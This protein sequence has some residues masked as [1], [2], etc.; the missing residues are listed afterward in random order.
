MGKN[1]KIRQKRIR[2]P[3][4]VGPAKRFAS[5]SAWPLAAV[6]ITAVC[7]SPALTNGF[8]NWDDESYVV[9]NALLRGPQWIGIF[10]RPVVS[11]Y[12]PLTV[13]SL[14]ANYAI[15][16]TEPWSYLLFNLLLHL[17]NTVLVFWFAYLLSDK[18]R[19]V[20][21]FT[22]LLFGIHPMHVE[23]VAWISERKDVLYALFFL[24][25]LIAYWKYL[26]TNRST[27][28]WAC[29]LLFACSLLSK[30]AAIVLPLVLLLLDYWKKRPF[31]RRVVLE[32]IPFFLV[33]VL[34]AV[35]TLKLQSVTAMI[36]LNLYPFWVRLFFA[37]YAIIVYLAR[38]F[39]PHPLSAFHPFPLPD[40]LGW[41]IYLSPIFLLALIFLIWHFRKNRLVVFGLLFF[42]INILLVLQLV[43][44]GLTIVSERYTYVPYIG[45]AFLVTMIVTR[46]VSAKRFI[47]A[48]AG[49][50][51]VFS[52]FGF[53]SFKRTQ[54]WKDSDSLWT[55]VINRYPNASLP[56][57]DRAQFNY[58]RAIMMEPTQ[59]KP[60]FQRVIDDCTVV[61]NNKEGG[62][63]HYF[64]RGV[65]SSSLKQYEN[66]LADFNACLSIN[67]ADNEALYGRGTL[68]VNH[69]QKYA[70]ALADFDRAIQID[71]QG[72]Y[73]LNRSICHYK[74]GE[75]ANAVADA[76]IASQ[77]GVA[78]PEN[79]QNIL[80]AG[81]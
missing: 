16:G 8:V 73:Y 78:I 37:S 27:G 21:L 80:N 39:V 77:K 44:I 52:A 35:I 14:A 41:T 43:P 6:L 81:R 13:L 10:T 33:S 51:V 72:R 42:L 66:A 74:L 75:L 3:E 56:H 62:R 65:A 20:A 25:S 7:L 1:E 68:L 26:Q 45:L 57:G 54:V 34:F 17:A 71:P 70:E 23:S 9:S 67:R 18:K 28:Y 40:H 60:F 53:L 64:M 11:N 49:A 15:S 58:S 30:P 38:F 2:K 59:A 79:Y 4:A 19:W 48:A 61:I 22:A 24:L 29:F 55:D 32:K 46:N 5:G 63:S 36:N 31:T 12:H 69:Y 76:Q 50:V 47:P